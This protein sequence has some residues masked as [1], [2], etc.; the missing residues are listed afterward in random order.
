MFAPM[1]NG[2]RAISLQADHRFLGRLPDNLSAIERGKPVV[3]QCQT[4]GR[5]A[6]A[7]SIL[8]AAGR[9]VIN[10][11][12]GFGAWTDAGLPVDKSD[13]KADVRCRFRTMPIRR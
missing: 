12:G 5:S 11:T 4:G 8:Q 9:E 7:A 13:A 10:M 1:R 3:T 2:S 6:I